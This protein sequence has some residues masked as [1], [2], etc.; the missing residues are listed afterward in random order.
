MAKFRKV[1]KHS[2][3]FNCR[4]IAKTLLI[5]LILQRKLIRKGSAYMVCDPETMRI[6]AP[7]ITRIRLRGR[8]GRLLIEINSSNRQPIQK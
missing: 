6:V 8:S 2:A 7:Y 4:P 1:K 5:A 3:I